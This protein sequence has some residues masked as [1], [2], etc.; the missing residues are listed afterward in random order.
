VK[1]LC[2][3]LQVSRPASAFFY[4][5][6]QPGS[7]DK[8]DVFRSWLHPKSNPLNSSYLQCSVT[9]QLPG[10]T[11]IHLSHQN[12]FEKFMDSSQGCISLKTYHVKKILFAAFL[13]SLS[14][15][16]TAQ[17]SKKDTLL[18]PAPPKVPVR[19]YKPPVIEKDTLVVAGKPVKQQPG[20]VPPPP[21]PP[22]PPPVIMKDSTKEQ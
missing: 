1:T 3:H 20:H 2:Q 15:M 19:A 5:L 17:I 14:G 21:P 12:L 6:P 7:S 18:K 16:A 13:I 22:P 4:I 10:K 9:H 8:A 11:R